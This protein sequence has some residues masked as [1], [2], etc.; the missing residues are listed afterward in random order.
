MRRVMSR[1]TQ[2][3][4]KER[5]ELEALLFSGLNGV[6]VD[7]DTLLAVV[8]ADSSGSRARLYA[9]E[10]LLR[11][12]ETKFLGVIGAQTVARLYASALR[13]ETTPELN[14]WGFLGE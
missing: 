6:A 10:V 1:D 5:R 13:D 4:S 3:T 11:R 14:L 9:C 2:E 12:D 8:R 7:D